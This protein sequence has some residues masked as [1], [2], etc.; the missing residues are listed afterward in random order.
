MAVLRAAAGP[1]PAAQVGA[2]WPDPDQ[3]GRALAALIADGL[4]VRRED[5]SVALPGDRA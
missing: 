3:R 1:V 4:A 5:G 2:A